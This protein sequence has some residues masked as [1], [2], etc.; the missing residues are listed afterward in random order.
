M[1]RRQTPAEHIR[2]QS[3]QKLEIYQ[4]RFMLWWKNR[5]IV[6]PIQSSG[7]RSAGGFP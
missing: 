7:G 3:L 1:I 5:R 2:S 6:S 4:Q